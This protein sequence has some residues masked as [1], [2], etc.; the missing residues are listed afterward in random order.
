M[1]TTK[2]NVPITLRTL[3]LVLYFNLAAVLGMLTSAA[4]VLEPTAV[5]EAQKAQP[6]VSPRG[7]LSLA[8]TNTQVLLDVASRQHKP[9]TP[10][11]SDSNIARLVAR[12][13][14]QSHYLQH[15]L[16]N[17]MASKFLDRYIEVLDGLH[18][19]FLQ[20][21]L[22]DF[23][24]YRTTLDDLVYNKGDTKPAR[25]IFA[26]FIKRLEQRV[27]YVAELMEKEKFD[28][29]GDDRYNL[30]R[31]DAPRPK[32]LAEAR[33]L[34]RQH[35]RYE[36][37]QE[38][39]NK[40][41]PDE[42]AKKITRR[43]ARVMRMYEDL[44]NADIFEIFLSALTHAYDP[45]SDYMGKSSLESFSINMSLSLYGIGALLQSEDGYC[46]IKE[47]VPGG[48]AAQSK[49][50][51]P[52]D[53][54]INV[55][56][57]DAEPVDV[58]DTPLKK[59][60]DLIRGPKG[61]VV[62]LTIIPA[63]AADPSSRKVI[64]LVR[65]EIKLED[66]EAKAKIIDLPLEDSQKNVRLGLI[67]LPSFY[68]DF[69]HKG[70]KE[71]KSTTVDVTKLLRKLKR[72]KVD[73]I[74]LDLR[75]NGGG[76]LEE[77]INLTGLF[78]KEG[79][80][81]QVKDHNGKIAVDADTDPSV[82]YDGPLIVLTSRFSASASEILAGALQDYGRALIVGDSSTHGKGTV[83]SL[84]KLDP[85]VQRAFGKPVENP[86]AVKLTIRKFYRA[87]GVSTQLKG[88][89]PDMVL[90]SA[91]NYAEVGES[92]LDNP[93]PCDTI[94]SAAYD[95]LNLIQP[96]LAELQKRSTNRMAAD[97]D[98]M[99]LQEDIDQYRKLLADKTV[100]LNEEQRL[101]EKQETEAKN[102]VRQAELKARPELKE[103]VYDIT[104]KLAEQ[105]GLP[106]PTPKTN[107]VASI[108]GDHPIVP[109]GPEP[110]AVKLEIKPK[111]N[112]LA[113]ADEA[114]PASAKDDDEDDS[115]EPK[116]PPVDTTLKEAKRI[117]TDLITMWSRANSVAV[118]N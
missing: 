63:D 13:L 32:D 115:A 4:E 34:W 105:P 92:S 1:V 93:L 28:F 83:Q 36:V 25:E 7:G 16:D 116:V 27:N 75:R 14:V 118:T 84:I 104:L 95:R 47:L 109:G 72:E 101:K 42:I 113:K 26:V 90:P 29:T 52:N 37:L 22:N 57:G 73:G 59:V 15:P 88:V 110:E 20:S 96:L 106:A 46:K 6:E 112:E 107:L 82:I 80:V 11:P 85:F 21:D 9:L 81:V 70:D 97:K 68:A 51:K 55:A 98:F 2:L 3:L 111:T 64:T 17:A 91:N 71:P 44:D 99:Y 23:E 45:H 62:N 66:Q 56:Q 103:T 33:Q 74:I 5:A 8:S 12:I 65:D 87:S 24:Q 69:D 10:S 54:I 67:D 79:P 40:E 30:N 60:V 31:K 48:P 53:R 41:K 61:T 89:V 102:K 117:L 50:L 86:G 18:L 58:L 43:Y 76:S 94:A 114:K 100:S 38:K 49:K 78:I 39:L 108:K 35:L 19:H 77:A